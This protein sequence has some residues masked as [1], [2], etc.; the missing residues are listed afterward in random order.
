MI[1]NFNKTSMQ[2]GPGT[3]VKVPSAIIKRR[4]NHIHNLPYGVS[5]IL[6]NN[7]YIWISPLPN[8]RMPGTNLEEEETDGKGPVLEEVRTTK[9]NKM[10]FGKIKPPTIGRSSTAT[11]IQF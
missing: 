7:G 9:Y 5:V 3:L 10:H 11:F 1:V 8:G 2:L 6:G 4:K